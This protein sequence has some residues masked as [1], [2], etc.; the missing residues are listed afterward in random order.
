MHPRVIEDLVQYGI[1]VLPVVVNIVSPHIVIFYVM[2]TSSPMKFSF[3]WATYII[4][5]I[6]NKTPHR[7]DYLEKA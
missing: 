1:Q 6:G 2:S 5:V 7:F 3:L 4:V